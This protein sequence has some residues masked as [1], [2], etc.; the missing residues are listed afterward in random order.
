MSETYY[1]VYPIEGLRLSYGKEPLAF[2]QYVFHAEDFSK[3]W[4]NGT[5]VERIS[6]DKL[7]ELLQND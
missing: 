6:K 2:F 5:K 7:I 3:N 1:A 4:P